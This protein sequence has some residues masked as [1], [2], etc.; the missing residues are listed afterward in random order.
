MEHLHLQMRPYKS[1]SRAWQY[2]VPIEERPP[3]RKQVRFYL[4]EEL[5]SDPMLPLHLTLF[6]AEGMAT[7]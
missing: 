2:D 1:R 6:F 4:D 5:G 3:R 7:Q